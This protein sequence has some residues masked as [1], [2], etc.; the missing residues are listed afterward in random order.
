MRESI[1]KQPIR[2]I[3]HVT[4]I[5]GDPQRNLDFYTEVLGLRLVKLTVNFDD[6]GTYHFYFGN[7]TG[8]P[9]TILTFFPYP[10]AHKGRRGA[11]QADAVSFA[12]PENSLDFWADH[13]KQHHIEFGEPVAHFGRQVLAFDDPD[14]LRLELVAVADGHVEPWQ[15]SPVPAE[16]AIRGFFGVTLIER[17]REKTAAVLADTMGLRLIGQEGDRYRYQGDEDAPGSVVDILEQPNAPH[18]IVAGGSI[19]H[20]AFRAPND[21]AQ[22]EWRDA[23]Q[24]SGLD[25]TPVRDRIY[26]HSIYFHEPGGV[27]FEIAT[28]APGFLVDEDL[29]GLGSALRLPPWLEA[30]RPEIEQVTQPLQLGQLAGRSVS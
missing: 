29:A 3:H 25:V 18:S 22:L 28:D 14:G 5:A 8:T 6:P 7:E 16:H 26:F 4:A 13:L 15:G 1:L 10:G 30:Q 19:H 27:L 21:D 17:S 23:I 12:V 11:G 2:G 9:G 20:V 24:A